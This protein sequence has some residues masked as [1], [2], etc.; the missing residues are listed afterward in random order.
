MPSQKILGGLRLFG[1]E[2]ED[3]ITDAMV[4]ARTVQPCGI[5]PSPNDE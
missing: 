4:A 2:L 3:T 1:D 5:L